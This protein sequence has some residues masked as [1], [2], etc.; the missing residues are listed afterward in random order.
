[1]N[2]KLCLLLASLQIAGCTTLAPVPHNR[3]TFEPA[4]FRAG[5][6]I[7]LTTTG[8]KDKVLKIVSITPEQVCGKDECIRAIDVKSVTRKE[9]SAMRTLGLVLLIAATVALGAAVPAPMGP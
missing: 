1:M 6:T 3:A 7:V 5:E 4:E 2:K 8:H 9:F